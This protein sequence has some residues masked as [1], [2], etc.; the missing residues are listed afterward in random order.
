[1]LRELG[2][3]SSP[4]VDAYVKGDSVRS[5]R[6]PGLS[7]PPDH[8]KAYEELQAQLE[9]ERRLRAEAIKLAEAIKKE[10]EEAEARMRNEIEFRVQAERKAREEAE[11]R[12]EIE[13]KAREEAE[14]RDEK[15]IDTAGLERAEAITTSAGGIANGLNP[16]LAQALAEM[17]ARVQAEQQAIIEERARAAAED[18]AKNETIELVSQKRGVFQKVFF[19]SRNR[20]AHRFHLR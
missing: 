6:S 9:V 17:M 2:C 11:A 1:M 12:L 7:I 15:R 19:H 13:R 16:M 10:W 4:Y 20:L 14:R 3:F 18:R 8:Q 5:A